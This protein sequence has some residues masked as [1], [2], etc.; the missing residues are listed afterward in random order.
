ME[1][2]N[3]VL[4]WLLEKLSSI[5]LRLI[6]V[7]DASLSKIADWQLILKLKNINAWTKK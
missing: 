3:R 6:A 4:L 1:L 2:L 7:L 5:M